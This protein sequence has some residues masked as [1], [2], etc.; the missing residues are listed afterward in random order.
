[1]YRVFIA[2]NR[3]RGLH[4]DFSQNVLQS[5]KALNRKMEQRKKKDRWR[6]VWFSPSCQRHDAM[7]AKRDLERVNSYD[8]MK[9]TMK[10]IEDA[11]KSFTDESAS[12]LES[13]LCPIMAA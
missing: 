4:I 8:A 7:K 9:V 13:K 5:V 2:Q 1:M 11:E 6:L 3:G 12:T 10:K